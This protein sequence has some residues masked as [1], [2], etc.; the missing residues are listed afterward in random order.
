MHEVNPFIIQ[1]DTNFTKDVM[2]KETSKLRA[3]TNIKLNRNPL[4]IIHQNYS[5]IER[6]KVCGV[7]Y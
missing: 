1:N 3:N 4:T 6:L 2:S 7:E 5:S